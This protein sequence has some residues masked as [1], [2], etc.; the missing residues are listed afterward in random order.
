MIKLT[1]NEMLIGKFEVNKEPLRIGGYDRK[2]AKKNIE[3]PC[4]F[5]HISQLKLSE[6]SKR[7]MAIEIYSE[8]L[9]RTVWLCSNELMALQVKEDDPEAVCFTVDEMKQLIKLQPT[10]EELRRLYDVKSVFNG[11]KIIEST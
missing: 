4:N 10:P 1:G 9:E 8:I 7:N 5:D 3:S 2:E 11:S 6:L